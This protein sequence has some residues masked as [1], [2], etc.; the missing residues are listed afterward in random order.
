MIMNSRSN[1]TCQKKKQVSA[2]FS[3]PPRGV[4]LLI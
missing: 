2:A 3:P 4:F 1:L